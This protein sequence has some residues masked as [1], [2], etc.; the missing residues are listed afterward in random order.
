MNEDRLRSHAELEKKADPWQL[1]RLRIKEH[2]LEAHL[3]LTGPG[4]WLS[5]NRLYEAI[6]AYAKSS[7]TVAD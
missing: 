6:Y 2:E 4:I 5:R 1:V 7:H 3:G